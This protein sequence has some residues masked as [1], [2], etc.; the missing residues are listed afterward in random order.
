MGGLGGLAPPPLH[1]M[2]PPPFDF[3]LYTLHCDAVLLASP[4]EG[5]TPLW[6]PPPPPKK[7]EEKRLGYVSV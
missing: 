5:L 1:I 2:P 3:L 4:D 7:K 6:P